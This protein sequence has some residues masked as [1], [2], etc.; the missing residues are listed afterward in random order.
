MDRMILDCYGWSDLDLAHGF[1]RNERSQT[2]Y[3]I[4]PET[5]RE[6][7]R[8]LLALDLEVAARERPGELADL[9]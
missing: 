4:S 5:R 7:L 8:R 9:L 6:V 1:H 3:T 2:R